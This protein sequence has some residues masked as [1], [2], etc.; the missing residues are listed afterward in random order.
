MSKKLLLQSKKHNVTKRASTLLSNNMMNKKKF[1]KFQSNRLTKKIS[2]FIKNESIE[3][4]ISRS[5]KIIITLMVIAMICSLISILSMA[6]RT[7]KLYNSPYTVLNTI[8]SVKYNLKELDDSL[9]K[10]IS[11]NDSNKR[12]YNLD[13]SNAA[14]ETLKKNIET[15]GEIFTGDKILVNEISKNVEILEPVRQDACSLINDNKK[16]RAMRLLDG[17]YSLQMELSQ[18]SIDAIYDAS[19]IEAKNFVNSSNIYRDLSV[20]AIIIVILVIIF[21]ST[22]VGKLLR[23]SL[24]EG[25][26][27]IKNIAKNLLEGNLK[28]DST[29]TSN[30]EMGEMS[31]DL[32]KSLE[33]LTS[34]IHNITDTLER[35]SNSDLN[36]D[37]D[38]S[39]YYKGDFLPIK[40]S[41]NK[42]VSSLN[43][44]FYDMREAIDFTSSSSEQ[45]AATTQMLSEGSTSQSESV[46]HLL[47]SFT[48]VLRQVGK[49]T[50][51]AY[52]ANE[53]S[54]R[55]KSIVADGSSK[56]NDLIKSMTDITNSS[57][58]IAEI[59]NTIEDIA[60]QTNL[61]ALNAAI[62]AAR[63]GDAG[64]GFAVVAEE[65]KRLASQ[66][67]EAVKN[68]TKIINNSLQA[69]I[70]GE[71]LAKETAIALT[72]IVD[73]VDDTTNLVKQI[74]LESKE[75]ANAIEK[76]TGRVNKI[77]DVVQ[78]NSAT[79]EEIAASTQELASQSQLI[80]D[81]LLIY[82]LKK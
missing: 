46:D 70:D 82:K 77:S 76:M 11:T 7:N 61:L 59:V 38:S 47:S 62:E 72:A 71:N 81:K 37:L 57:K 14:A 56:M 80:S 15:L 33:M 19:E 54:N 2:L 35:L 40:E 50:D 55:T 31:N 52:E 64:K 28:I 21:I 18:N 44:T 69:V 32:I 4:E 13:L 79:A 8:S 75:Q 74:A 42:I 20:L 53:F 1:P 23:Q 60:S 22:L 73:N 68:T 26:N 67:S 12:N 51:N 6:L 10:A 43:T 29:Y 63:A 27:N 3:K 49:N 30:D 17:S 41:L 5:F 16:D 48:S 39:I 66:S 34:Y 78:T 45:L 36:I 65:V 58:Q 24:L 9:Y 25:I